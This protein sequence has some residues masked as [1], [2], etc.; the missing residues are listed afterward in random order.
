M[1]AC[2]ALET[3]VYRGQLSPAV[4]GR[5]G[6]VCPRLTT[7]CI[8]TDD[9]DLTEAYKVIPLLPSLL[10]QLRSLEL[11]D[12]KSEQQLPDLSKLTNLLSLELEALKFTAECK[13]QY[14]PPNLNCLVSCGMSAIPSALAEGRGVF[15]NLIT[16]DLGFAFFNLETLADLLLAA[17][18]LQ[19][20]RQGECNERVEKMV[21][22]PCLLESLAGPADL[23]L[24]NHRLQTGLEIEQGMLY[25]CCGPKA[26][27]SH[28]LALIA[29]LPVATHIKNCNL[30]GIQPALLSPLLRVFPNLRGLKLHFDGDINDIILQDVTACQELITLEIKSCQKIS[31]MGLIALCQRLP[32]LRYVCCDG[33]GQITAAVLESC[34]KLLLRHGLVVEM[35]DH[36]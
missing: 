25:V 34:A 5:L 20:I 21:I 4:L 3:L 11:P 29:A 22:I 2:P 30:S 28:S 13:W 26:P 23:F 27:V 10:P 35:V 7:L 1:G 16:L 8:Q 31:P 14:L 12:L 15:S 24:L 18:A 36:S 6:K 19:L 33:C 17:P 9:E 32:Q